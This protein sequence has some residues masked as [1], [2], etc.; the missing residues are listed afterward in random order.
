MSLDATCAIPFPF[1]Y[2]HSIVFGSLECFLMS[3]TI[4]ASILTGQ[5]HSLFASWKIVWFFT[6]FFWFSIRRVTPS[7]ANNDLSDAVLWSI[8]L[9]F[10]Q[11][12]KSFNRNCSVLVLCVPLLSTRNR[13]LCLPVM[14]FE[15]LTCC[16]RL[17]ERFNLLVLRTRRGLIEIVRGALHGFVRDIEVEVWVYPR[18]LEWG[19]SCRILRVQGSGRR[20]KARHETSQILRVCL[21]HKILYAPVPRIP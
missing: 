19:L 10:F 12:A 5:L 15:L 16:H 18:F 11:K 21:I 9:L 1:L 2:A 8:F 20:T 4:C 6:P 7:H 13:M 3:V 14:P 17:L